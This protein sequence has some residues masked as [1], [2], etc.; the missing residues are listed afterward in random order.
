M[1]DSVRTG[2]CSSSMLLLWATLACTHARSLTKVPP[3]KAMML[4][5]FWQN[6]VQNSNAVTIVP[7]GKT[8]KKLKAV[9]TFQGPELLRRKLCKE[10]L[11]TFTGI[12][13]ALAEGTDDSGSST[14]IFV[15]LPAAGGGA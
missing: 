15:S 6:T 4:A 8:G 3:V 10:Q 2:A 1:R 11:D 14:E 12:A 13:K 5:K 9:R 7:D